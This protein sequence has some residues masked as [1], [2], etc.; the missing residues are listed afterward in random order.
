MAVSPL[1]FK[2][3]GGLTPTLLPLNPHPNFHCFLVKNSQKYAERIEFKIAFLVRYCRGVQPGGSGGKC[4]KFRAGVFFILGG[5]FFS[6]G[7]DVCTV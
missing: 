5:I 1:F 4:L 2:W 3:L 6:L 7:G